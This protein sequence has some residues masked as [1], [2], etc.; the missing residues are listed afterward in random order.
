MALKTF[1][2]IS[3]VNNLSDARYC[4]G[5]GVDM[6]GFALEATNPDFIA[7]E[8]YTE[9]IGWLSG[10]KFVGEFD[11]SNLKEINKILEEYPINALQIA[12][13]EVIA[14]IQRKKEKEDLEDFIPIIFK[15]N[16]AENNQKALNF[17]ELGNLFEK[18]KKTVN[19]FLLENTNY[20]TD[21][22]DVHF[23]E[24]ELTQLQKLTA[25][26]PVILGF[27]INKNNVNNLIDN[28]KI[29]GISL[30]GGTEIRAGYKDFDDLA[31]ILEIIE[32]D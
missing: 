20:S 32:I 11:K 13:E 2:K 14:E 23:S 4:A 27:S 1:V 15:I 16:L 24:N 18:Y 7:P 21:N 17:D 30:K 3:A 28:S 10:V 6:L 29:T 25:K 31:E 26:F 8:K 19:Y 5:M 22:I 9:I 12:N